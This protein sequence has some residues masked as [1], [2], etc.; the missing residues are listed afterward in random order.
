[1]TAR[2]RQRRDRRERA[3]PSAPHPAHVAVQGATA[4]FPG[5]LQLLVLISG[6]AALVYQSVWIRQLSLILGSTNYAVGT[7]LAAFMAGLGVG[8]FVLGRRA[9]RTPRPLALY[10]ALELGIGLVGLVSPFALAQGND[11]YA[12][13]YRRL[14]ES[15]GLLTIARFAIGFGFVFVPAFLMGGTLPAATRH[16]VAGGWATGPAVGRLYAINTLGAA[17]GALLLPY[18][19]LPALGL[20]ATLVL[21]ALT[22]LAIAAAAVRA[23]RTY[24]LGPP[25]SAPAATGERSRRMGLLAAFFVSGFVALALEVLWNRFFSMYIGSSIY[26]YAIVL[27][28]YLVGIFAGGLAGERLMA[29]GRRPEHVFVGSLVTVLAALALTVPLMDRIL[30]AQL[31]VLQVFGPSFW[32]FQAAAIFATGLVLLAPT[33][34]FGASFPAV[35][36]ALTRDAGEAGR[37]LGLAYLV[38]TGG[39]TLGSIA[40]S[41]FLIPV[42]GLRASFGVLAAL[43][44]VSALVAAARDWTRRVGFVGAVVALS[45]LPS[46]LPSWDLRRMHS[47]INNDARTVLVAA[48]QGVLD[49]ALAAI[50]VLDLRD[51]VDATVSVARYAD[52]EVALLVNGKGDASDG[53]DMFTQLVLAHLPLTVRP[54]AR[55][56]LVVGMGSG[57]TLGAVLRHP[58]AHVDLVEISPEV[59]E[60]GGHHFRR[61]NRGA[62]DDPRVTV[63]VEDGRN[64]IA[65]GDGREYDV[66]ISEPSNPWMSARACAP[67]ASWRSGSTTTGWRSTTCARFSRPCAATSRTSTSSRSITRST[68]RATWCCWRPRRRSTSARCSR[69]SRAASPRTTCARSASRGPPPWYT[70]SSSAPGRSRGSWE[71]RPSTPTIIRAS[72]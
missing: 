4:R 38:N 31:A 40:A 37:T 28:L 42:L 50:Q 5:Q 56:V 57:V 47:A 6:A 59:L 30:Y 2:R 63:H 20:R 18:A 52:G 24:A 67:E 66:I 12:S 7:V 39:T 27:T 29:A 16:L 43:V 62:L 9:D 69:R 44:A 25:A 61:V 15:P 36:A 71:G 23:A 68:S 51:G 54:E 60:L 13:F 55:D 48:D 10:A 14:H 58:V 3:T 19:L 70:D 11:V 45:A 26:S 64:F 17:C 21:T 33:M 41:F 32:S 65:F 22:N 35:T 53:V 46:V 72:S 49:Q 8:A 34:A 1:M